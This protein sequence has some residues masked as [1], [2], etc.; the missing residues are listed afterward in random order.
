MRSVRSPEI[1]RVCAVAFSLGIFNTG[2]VV[3]NFYDA[4]DGLGSGSRLDRRDIDAEDED[5]VFPG[6]RANWDLLADRSPPREGLFERYDPDSP[7]SSRNSSAGVPGTEVA[8]GSAAPLSVEPE[9]SGRA[10]LTLSLDLAYS[11]GVGG[12]EADFIPGGGDYV[13]YD[14]TLFQGPQNLQYS[15]DLHVGTVGARVGGRFFDIFRLEAIGG[16]SV[17]ALYLEVRGPAESASDTGVA[18]GAHLGSRATITPHPVFDVYA[19]GRVHL[20]GGVQESRQFVYLAEA[21]VAGNLH[22]TSNL[23]VYGGWRWW[24]YVEDIEHAS[25]LEDIVL[26]G[27]S[28]GGLVRF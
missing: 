3:A 10:H 15:Y 17:T 6:V 13:D 20:L 14:G 5:G 11:A 12:N 2:C 23:S 1:V 16:L 8:P 27:P 9:S 22:L 7:L 21:E 18:L 19:E 25:N 24:S 28:F 26:S 4:L